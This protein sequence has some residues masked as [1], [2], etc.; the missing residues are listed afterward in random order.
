MVK[1]TKMRTKVYILVVLAVV[2]LVF[3]SNERL[4]AE[5]DAGEQ[6]GLFEMS[7][8]ELMDVEVISASRQAQKISE[9]SV[10]VSVI[11]SEDIHYS[12]LTAIPEIIQFYPGMDVLQIDRNRYAVGI[13]GLH[14]VHS[15]HMQT[16]ID[17]RVADSAIFGGAEWFRFPIL[18]EDIKQ[19]EIVR[20]P[21]GAAWGANA[22]TGTIN[23][24]TKDP[25]DCQGW[26][27]STTWNHF[28]EGY[29]HVR[30]GSKANDWSW[31]FS[32]GYGEHKT[33][34]D[35]I[36]DDNFTSRDF[37]RDWRFNSKA[38]YRS[39]ERTKWTMG[40][41]YSNNETGDYEFVGLFRG[42]DSRFEYTRTFVK[43]DH[44][45]ENGSTGYVQW[46]TNYDKTHD[47]SMA[48]EWIGLENDIE[49]Q[50]NFSPVENHKIAL[51]GNFRWTHINTYS[52]RPQDFVFQDE[53]FSFESSGLFVTDRWTITD[54]LDVEA[55]I[56]GEWYSRTDIDW[57][58]RLAA[59]YGLDAK[60]DH[61]LRIA[62]GRGF[63]TP[64]IGV[65]E[66]SLTRIAH[67]LVPGAYIINHNTLRDEDLENED[68]WSLEAG[69]T[70]RLSE[71]LTFKTNA[72]Y[73]R[74]DN[75]IQTHTLTDPLSLGRTFTYLD[76]FKGADSWGNELELEMIGDSSTVS[77][78]YAY[79]GF[80]EEEK[81]CTLR[82]YPP[83][84]HKVGLRGR[85]FLKDRW[86]LNAN[87][88]YTDTTPYDQSGVSIGS[89]LPRNAAPPSH[90]FDLVLTKEFGKGKNKV[91]FGVLNVFDKQN[92]IMQDRGTLSPHNTPG[93]TYFVR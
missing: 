78:W 17:G 41:G 37:S 88:R 46:F 38:V 65:D 28:G 54:R 76:N 49:A 5:Q 64:Q 58:G 87:Y 68:T 11:T 16:L 30:W 63:R 2:L 89:G 23:I 84:R 72:Y 53:P 20:G 29:N 25:D 85:L 7:L 13:R 42:E 71:K 75:L 83:A 19:I 34:E 61:V 14:D 1:G 70:S 74:F 8:E 44:E 60:K 57:A 82:S 80:Q 62:A 92:G 12:G 73:Q 50:L 69:Y 31:Y 9:S 39:S 93:R 32:L 6:E 35:V 67:P 59:L 91:M 55:Q 10:P 22:L 27:T 21:S 56:R 66:F 90:R 51:G 45:F 86:S 36:Q 77:V 47:Q 33:S 24:I 43:V 26:L 3:G 48:R 15:E 18:M 81:G 79:N 40:L 4:L 52:P